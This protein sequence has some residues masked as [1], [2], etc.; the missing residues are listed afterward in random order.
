MHRCTFCHQPHITGVSLHTT[1]TPSDIRT[2]IATALAEPKSR[3]RGAEFEVAFYGG[4]F[5]GLRPELQEQ[6]LRTAQK[7]VDGGML[8]GIRLSTHPNMFD[9]HILDLLASFTVTTIELG[10]QSFDN[11]VLKQARRGHTSE[12]A[13]HAIQRL[14]E[15]GIAVGIHLMVGL[16]GDSHDGSLRSTDK[17]IALH[18]ASARIH[19][20]LVIHN[21]LLAKQHECGEYAALSL[22]EAVHTCKEMLKRF[23]AHN[24]PVIRIGLQP[25]ESM[26]RHIVAGPY[27]PAFRQLVDSALMYDYIAERCEE[28]GFPGGHLTIT[29]APQDISTVRGQKNANLA[30]LRQAFNFT[31]VNV[32]PDSALRRGEF[33]MNCEQASTKNLTK[34]PT[35]LF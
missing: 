30:T 34:P 15:L 8:T 1:V 23:Q 22:T 25:T 5:T 21:T 28:S 16:P 32:I 27:H 12:E 2:T 33:Q 14:Q 10:V 18:P 7:Y 31:E 9:E 35:Q 26:E 6:F 19:P 29:A 20:T 17:A 24:I 3:A 4:T 11:A 13:E